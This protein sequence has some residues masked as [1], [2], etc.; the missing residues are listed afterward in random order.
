MNQKYFAWI[1]YLLGMK[2]IYVVTSSYQLIHAFSWET[3]FIM[4][5]CLHF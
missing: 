3:T 2:H 1:L 5:L 4:C